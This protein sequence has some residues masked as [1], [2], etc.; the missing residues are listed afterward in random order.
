MN[1]LLINLTRFGDLLQSR[2]LVRDLVD[3]GHRVGMV[4]LENFAAAARLLPDIAHVAPLPGSALLR[5]SAAEP[6]PAARRWP[7]AFSALESWRCD[8]ERDF[9]YED[10]RNLTATVSARLLC[11]LLARSRPVTGFALDAE[12]FA[13]NT[14]PW[15]AF[16]L[17][18][19]L[20][21]GNSPF[22]IVDLFRRM[23]QDAAIARGLRAPG[24]ADLNRPDATAEQTA[25]EF[26]RSEAPA[27]YAG[28]V[29]LQLGASRDERRLPT[30]TFAELGGLLWEKHRLCSVLLGHASELP[31]VER[32]ALKAKHPFI[33]LCGRTDLKQLAASLTRLRLLVSNDTGTLHLAAGLGT[34][35]LGVYLA[36]AQPFDTGPYRGGSC[37]V[38]PDLPCHPCPFG[39]PCPNVFACREHIPAS[40]LFALADA[41]LNTGR[42][43]T[44]TAPGARVWL[45]TFDEHGFMDL[46]SLSGHEREDRTRW[47]ALQRPLLRQFIDSDP[48]RPFAPEA[49]FAPSVGPGSPLFSKELDEAVM[50]AELLAGQAELLLVRP[51][52]T[53][54]DKLTTTIRRMRHLLEDH[55]HLAALSILFAQYGEV[56]D[57]RELPTPLKNFHTLIKALRDNAISI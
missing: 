37:T 23:G 47:M 57:P 43:P 12:G 34:P 41:F 7:L 49:F 55:P 26:L 14:N 9:P 10:V 3:Q 50:L 38:E 53:V 31:L 6:A 17:G 8:L 22:N 39:R 16:T 28:F 46:R 24:A 36:T 5:E 4:C 51:L 18:S 13:L 19:T 20:V 44:G 40:T 2:A 15:S 21:R 35:I 52:P 27:E 25:E 42:W 29:G 1:I 11:G 33:S 56:H 32:Y 54:R 45:S 30:A 48:Q